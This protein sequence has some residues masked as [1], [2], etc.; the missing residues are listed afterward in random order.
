[1]ATGDSPDTTIEKTSK[2]AARYIHPSPDRRSPC[3]I[4]LTFDPHMQSCSVVAGTIMAMGTCDLFT[5]GKE[6]A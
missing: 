1:V 6:A 2:A 3:M 4:C 5:Y